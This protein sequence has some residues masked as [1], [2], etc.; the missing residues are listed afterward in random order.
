[1][2]F[3]SRFLRVAVLL[4]VSGALAGGVVSRWQARTTA[5][6]DAPDSEVTQNFNEAVQLIED[7]Y[8]VEPDRERL[9]KASISGMLHT[10]DPHSNFFD[11][12]EFNEMQEEQSSRFYGIGVTINER[13]GR[14]YVLGVSKGMPADHAGLRYGDAIVAVDG[15]STNGWRQAD[16]LKHVRGEKGVPVEI[17]VERAGAPQP[18]SVK[19]T[20]DEVPYPSVRNHFI[21]RPGTGYIALTGGFNQATSDEMQAAIADLKKQGMTSLV[22]DLRRNPGGLLKEAI[23]VAE[24]F[25]PRG[26]GIVSVRGREGLFSRPRTYQSESDDPETFP[27]VVLINGESASASEIV[28][29]AIQDQDRGLIVGED[30][31]GKGLVQSVFK[32]PGG[33]GLTLTTAKYYT[34]SGRLIQREYSGVSLYDYYRARYHVAGDGPVPQVSPASKTVY[35]PTGR[36]L[37]G[38]GGITPDI[39][40]KKSEEDVYWR[41]ACFEFARQLAAGTLPGLAEYKVAKIEHDYKLRGNEY[42]LNDQVIA[43]FRDFLHNH[44]KLRRLEGGLNAKLDYARRRI[45]AEVITA[46]YGLEAADQFLSESDEQMQRAIEALPKARQLSETAKLFPPKADGRQ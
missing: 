21:A 24:S 3:Q 31:F 40:V 46:A 27:L 8:V 13:N 35:T 44:P 41:D 7:N 42:Q 37:H 6:A 18:I 36:P 29:G 30:S 38:G 10:L 25:L 5:K 26:A 33:T 23:Q 1:M 34:P 20:R 19:I 17:T 39:V 15:K 43:A 11:R 2:K 4:I 28:A 32:I 14:I 9:T 12:R 45:R 22:L 16:A